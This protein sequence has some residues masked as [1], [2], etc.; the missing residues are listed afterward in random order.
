MIGEKVRIALNDYLVSPALKED[1]GSFVVPPL[2]GDDASIC[3][4]IA[5]AQQKIA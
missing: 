4:A 1:R 2:L 5:L 3:G